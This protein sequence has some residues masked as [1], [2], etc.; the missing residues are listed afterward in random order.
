MPHRWN[1]FPGT[2]PF[3]ARIRF[4]FI[5]NR[6]F[7]PFSCPSWQVAAV[8]AGLGSVSHLSHAAE[9]APATTNSQPAALEALVAD[10]LEHNPEL[11]FY[12]AEIAAAKGERRTAATLANPELAAT[13]GDKR[14]PDRSLVGEVLAWSA[15]VT[16]TF[17]RSGR[18]AIPK[19]MATPHTGPA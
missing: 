18:T 13:V 16:K 14:V 3:G 10:V 15:P 9:P 4:A 5:M 2:F 12:R 7:V 8:L 19:G 17:A 1:C 6:K 11:N